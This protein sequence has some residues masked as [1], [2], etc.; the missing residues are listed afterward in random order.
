MT[1]LVHISDLHFGAVAEATLE[2]L[3]DTIE[4]LAP[5]AVV[6]SGD[7]TQRALRKQ[8]QGAAAFLG[9]I[10]CE[11]RIVV[12]GNHDIPLWNPVRRFVNP[13][14]DFFRYITPETYPSFSNSA[15]AVIGIDTSRAL[16][17]SNGRI[18][19]AQ[20]EKIRRF[21]ADQAPE[22][23]RV[24]VA[25]HPF[26]IPE[27]DGNGKLVGRAEKALAGVLEE[28]V[29]LLLTGHRHQAWTSVLGT[30]LLT[31]HCGTTT[32]RRTRGETNC[33][34][35]LRI[36]DESIEV[37]TWR[38]Q[39]STECFQREDEVENWPRQRR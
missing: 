8:Y 25:H 37:Q 39:D 5:D 14:R 34:H 35:E 19:R 10:D 6:V 20:I 15:V 26:V 2:P 11:T 7:L 29:D 33:F 36:L 9:R 18:N 27:D 12:P 38:W 23:C 17:F 22:L 16:T 31:V 28:H 13:R 32:S 1:T 21:F 30:R 24:V 3:L 4:N